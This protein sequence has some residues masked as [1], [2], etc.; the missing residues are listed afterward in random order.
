VDAHSAVSFQANTSEAYAFA[1]CRSTGPHRSAIRASL[2]VFAERRSDCAMARQAVDQIGTAETV[3][4][5]GDHAP[6]ADYYAASSRPRR[7][8]ASAPND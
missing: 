8:S 6:H 2:A 1:Y 7:R 4:R 5:G 3:T